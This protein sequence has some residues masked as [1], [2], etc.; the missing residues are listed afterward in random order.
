MFLLPCEFQ[1]CF[2][3]TSPLKLKVSLIICSSY[4]TPIDTLSDKYS[5]SRS[6]VFQYGS[7]CL[8]V[9]RQ[10]HTIILLDILFSYFFI[11]FWN[12]IILVCYFKNLIMF[13]F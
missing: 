7:Y 9:G 4:S 5:K 10:V 13:I 11:P 2:L 6:T 3:L 8:N 12:S 1:K